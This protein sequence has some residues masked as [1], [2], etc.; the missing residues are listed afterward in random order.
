MCVKEED[1][2]VIMNLEKGVLFSLDWNLGVP[3]VALGKGEGRDKG[4]PYTALYV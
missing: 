2:K 1:R 4:K 3:S